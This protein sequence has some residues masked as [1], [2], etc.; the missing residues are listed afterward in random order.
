MKIR[1]FI[2]NHWKFLSVC[3]TFALII[4]LLGVNIST[5]NSVNNSTHN[6]TIGKAKSEFIVTIGS[7]VEAAGISA[8]YIC[9]GVNDNV[10][11]QNALNALPASGGEIQDLTG[12]AYNFTGA[13]TRAIPN[14]MTCG[15]GMSTTFSGN[16]PD[17][18]VG[19]NGWTFEN[20]ST[21]AN[22]ISVGSYT[23]IFN[24]V[25][26]GTTLYTEKSPN[27]SLVDNSLTAPTGRTAS[28]VIAASNAPASVKAQADYVCT[29]AADQ[30]TIA[31][32]LAVSGAT[33][34]V[35]LGTVFNFSAQLVVPTGLTLEFSNATI[36]PLG[37]FDVFEVQGNAQLIGNSSLIDYY[38]NS[39]TG[40]GIDLIAGNG[41]M[42]KGKNTAPVIEGWTQNAGNALFKLTATAGT[43]C[44]IW[45]AAF[46]NNAAK[47]CTYAIYQTAT[48]SVSNWIHGIVVDNLL[49]QNCAHGITSIASGNGSIGESFYYG[50]QVESGANFLET[51]NESAGCVN[52][53][54]EISQFDYSAGTIITEAGNNNYYTLQG[55]PFSAISNTGSR[56]SFIGPDYS[57]NTLPSPATIVQ[58]DVTLTNA[59]PGTLAVGGGGLI[60]VDTYGGAGT[61]NLA[62]ITGGYAGEIIFLTPYNASHVVTVVAGYNIFTAGATGQ[63]NGASV[64]LN[65]TRTI[66]ELICDGTN[67]RQ[68]GAASLN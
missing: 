22:G 3:V 60:F 7:S 12:G 42:D 43:N 39:T 48:G 49:M 54:F 24:N 6:V 41:S 28:Y 56:N 30:V 46:Y 8:D 38:D 67:W 19:G 44:Y 37:N 16:S 11:W 20:L 1:K 53:H 25:Q 64:A 33:K 18:T 21:N 32:A 55:V 13:V 26:V 2:K 10:Q 23:Y 66:L 58:T 61:Q 63:S 14:V 35:C 50:I 34:V 9:S 17:F 27:S 15:T 36:N 29:G 45:G 51:V 65:T 52:N 57:Y 40:N 5:I 4:S 62:T 47:G 31:A 59:S 68:V